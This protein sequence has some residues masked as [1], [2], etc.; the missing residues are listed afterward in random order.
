MKKQVIFFLILSIFF[1]LTNSAFAAVITLPNPLG[2]T[3]TFEELVINILVFLDGVLA[4]LA[5]IVFSW[6]GVLFL[7]ST[8]NESQVTKAKK[9]M[10]YGVVGLAIALSGALI[11][12]TIR[13]VIGTPTT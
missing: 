6:A 3:D 11:I 12:S 1:T 9:A 5:A 13:Y 10:I 4:G 2:S 8:G 7:T